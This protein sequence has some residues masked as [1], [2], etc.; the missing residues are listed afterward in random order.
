MEQDCFN[1]FRK[2]TG[3]KNRRE[4]FNPALVPVAKAEAM[5]LRR[6]NQFDYLLGARRVCRFDVRVAGE[7]C[8][9]GETTLEHGRMWAEFENV[10]VRVRIV[11]VWQLAEGAGEEMFYF[12]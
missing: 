7:D 4:G 10:I 9:G 3:E 12:W 8:V 5:S 6:V 1:G 11:S 2:F